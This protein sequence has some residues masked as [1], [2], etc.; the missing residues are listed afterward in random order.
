MDAKAKE[1]SSESS[2]ILHNQR[3]FSLAIFSPDLERSYLPEEKAVPDQLKGVPQK[4]LVTRQISASP[5]E[6]VSDLINKKTICKQDIESS[7]TRLSETRQMEAFSPL[8]GS[9]IDVMGRSKEDSVPLLDHLQASYSEPSTHKTLLWDSFQR[10]SGIGILHETLP[11]EVGDL[12]LNSSTSSETTFKLE[13]KSYV[14]SDAF[15]DDVGKRQAVPELDSNLRALLTSYEAQKKLSKIGKGSHLSK[16]L[17][18]H[19]VEL[20]PVAQDVQADDTHSVLDT[21]DMFIDCTKPSSHM[22]LDERTQTVSPLTKAFLMEQ[23][24]RTILPCRLGKFLPHLKGK[25]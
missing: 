2:S 15:P 5:T 6:D 9:G 8:V 17:E 18:Q 16:T 3:E 25:S 23:K 14:H 7:A 19:K 12:S 1:V 4:H 20:N 13:P 24:L 10:L 11:E 21:Q 22:S